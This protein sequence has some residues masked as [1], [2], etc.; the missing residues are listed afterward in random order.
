[1]QVMQ[2]GMTVTLPACNCP[3][4]EEQSV[5]DSAEMNNIYVALDLEIA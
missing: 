1:M 3:C 2:V 5:R 4:Q